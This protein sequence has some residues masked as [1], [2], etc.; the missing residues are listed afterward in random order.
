MWYI[1]SLLS[2]K[3]MVRKECTLPCAATW[4]NFKQAPDYK[5]DNILFSQKTKPNLV[6]VYSNK[7]MYI[8]TQNVYY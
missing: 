4:N 7:Y 8:N 6:H 2:G 3:N 1:N 5:D